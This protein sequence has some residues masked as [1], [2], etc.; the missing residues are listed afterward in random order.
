[1]EFKEALSEAVKQDRRTHTDPFLL[2]ARI[3][4]II[5]ND[6][7]VKKAA[8]EYFD[9]DCTYG[10]TE[11][12]LSSFPAKDHHSGNRPLSFLSRLFSRGKKEDNKI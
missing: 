4:D 9:L 10:L 1:M 2:Y 5:G 3:S 12:L 6:Y 11:S 7:E 8:K